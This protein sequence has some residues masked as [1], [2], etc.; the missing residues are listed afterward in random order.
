MSTRAPKDNF[1]METKDEEALKSK[2]VLDLRNACERG[3]GH[4]KKGLSLIHIYVRY[5]QSR[6]KKLQKLSH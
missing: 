2:V 5:L 4:D 1:N 3:V 6:T